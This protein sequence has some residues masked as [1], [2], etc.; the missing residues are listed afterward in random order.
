M[1]PVTSAALISGGASI[2]GGLMGGIGQ[3]NANK[4][5]LKIAREQ[6][7]FQERM[8]NTAVQ[9]RMADLRIAG[10]NPILA[11]TY[12]ASTP[13]GASTQFGNVGLAAAQGMHSVGAAATSALQLNKL[14][15]EI[16]QTQAQTGLTRQQTDA[17]AM[18]AKVSK[19]G[20]EGLQMA[21]DY[22]RGELPN[23]MEFIRSLPQIIQA[24][25][26]GVIEELR[27]KI[28]EGKNFMDDTVDGM[29]A[30]Q[31]D[32]DQRFMENWNALQ[33]FI[34]GLQNDIKEYLP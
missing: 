16:E 26:Q 2:V 11:G 18:I 24:P 6:M 5:N 4:M 12:D 7:R 17:I 10:I 29:R 9:R 23:I 33:N 27:R 19:L 1:E 15:A 28:E 31:E 22:L 13:A 34:R 14:E 30:W 32:M 25:T 8:S 21:L 20:A 3:S